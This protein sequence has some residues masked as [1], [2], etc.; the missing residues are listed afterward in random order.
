MDLRTAVVETRH[1]IL[2]P[3]AESDL[4]TLHFWRN[5]PHFL[6]LCSNRRGCV[7]LEEFKKELQQD[8]ERDRHLQMMIVLK[9]TGNPIGT[10]YSY[11]LKEADGYLFV[12]T[13]LEVAHQKMGYGAE[14]FAV[15]V[16]YLFTK[17]SVFKIYLEVYEYN[18]ESLAVMRSACLSEEGRFRGHR[19]L[20]G[21][22]YDTIRF[23]VY[24]ED[25]ERF[26]DFLKLLRYRERR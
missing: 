7:S 19:K 21:R 9:R 25:L 26:Q 10:I 6:R 16:Q 18:H 11:G 20:D 2:R 24:H 13:F 14:A 23:A 15:F 12:T 8:F 22:R 5:S 1:V 4:E 3:I 17:Y